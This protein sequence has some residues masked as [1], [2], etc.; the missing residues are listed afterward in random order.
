MNIMGKQ[1]WYLPT[2]FVA[3]VA[4]STVLIALT[5][6]HLFQLQTH[7]EEFLS[8]EWNNIYDIFLKETLDG[9]SKYKQK[10]Q[11]SGVMEFYDGYDEYPLMLKL[12]S[13]S[14]QI[15]RMLGYMFDSTDTEIVKVLAKDKR[16]INDPYIYLQE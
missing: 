14:S 13:E 9:F 7:K 2:A 5:S 12:K 3:I 11:G 10:L 1:D 16:D 6:L 4:F 8:N 15:D